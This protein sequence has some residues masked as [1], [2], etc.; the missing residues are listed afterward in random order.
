[1]QGG[2]AIGKFGPG[3]QLQDYRCQAC[4]G[5]DAYGEQ[6][7]ARVFVLDAG[8]FAY[9]LGTGSQGQAQDQH[10]VEPDTGIPADQHVLDPAVGRHQPAAQDAD[11]GC[12]TQAGVAAGESMES[13]AT[14]GLKGLGLL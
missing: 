8:D 12:N 2:R 4:D 11:K 13:H 10:Q 1:L 6:H 9:F 3:G 14:S 7:Q 5:S